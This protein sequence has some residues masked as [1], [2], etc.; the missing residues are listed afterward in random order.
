MEKAGWR[1]LDRVLLA[2]RRGRRAGGPTTGRGPGLAAAGA[3]SGWPGGK[4]LPRGFSDRHEQP[5]GL[6]HEAPKPE[7]PIEADRTV[8]LGIDHE[9]EYRRLGTDRAHD[10]IDHEGRSKPLPA[11]PL[12]DGEAADQPGRQEWVA[13]QPLRFLGRKLGQRQAGG[14]KR[15]KGRDQAGL[16]EGD[17][18]VAYPPL[19]V[20]RDK[21]AKIPVEGRNAA[22][23]ACANM[24]RAQELNSVRARQ[25]DALIS[26]R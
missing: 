11:G 18:T 4:E 22:G 20:L 9:R 23:E 6:A 12:I 24:G 15:V 14:R 26:V 21:L 7:M 16:V 17:E 2:R 5:H 13:G 1:R 8:I 19:D 10:R 3:L 25:R